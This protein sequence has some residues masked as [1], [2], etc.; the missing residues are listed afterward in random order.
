[1]EDWSDQLVASAILFAM[2]FGVKI[3]NYG[4]T[5]IVWE[6]ELNLRQLLVQYLYYDT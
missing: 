3:F 2:S 6:Q 5:V 4:D 1:M